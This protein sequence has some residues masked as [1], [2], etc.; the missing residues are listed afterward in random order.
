[1]DYQNVHLTAHG[2]FDATR[3]GP[4]HEAL[5][6]PLH[7]GNQLIQTRNAKQR[8]GMGH[9]SL[10]RLIVHRGL[11]LPEHDPKAYARNRSQQAHWQR[12]KR[13]TVH[14]RPLKYIYEYDADGNRATG[15]D[16]K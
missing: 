3:F 2:L 9:A 8:E 1:M 11:P 10:D 6:D 16:G 15:E 12:D 4:R 7:F 13:V 14:L 5:I